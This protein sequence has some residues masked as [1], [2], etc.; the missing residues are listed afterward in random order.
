MLNLEC[1]WVCVGGGRYGY[2]DE[3]KKKLGVCLIMIW[4]LEKDLEGQLR[5]MF[6]S[7]FKCYFF[8][9]SFF[10]LFFYLGWVVV[11]FWCAFIFVFML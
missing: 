5:E 11:F 1:F 7:L 3:V 8:G 4:E 10:F 9:K 2:K 6:K